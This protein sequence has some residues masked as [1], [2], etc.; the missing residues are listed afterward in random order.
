M[1]IVDGD[2]S[3]LKEIGFIKG[4]FYKKLK[5]YAHEQSCGYTGSVYKLILNEIL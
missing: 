4:S 3:P 2:T 1:T 5:N